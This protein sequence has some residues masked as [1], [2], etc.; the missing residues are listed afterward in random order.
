[1]ELIPAAL[2]YRNLNKFNCFIVN[3]DEITSESGNV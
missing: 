2:L 3:K 1:M